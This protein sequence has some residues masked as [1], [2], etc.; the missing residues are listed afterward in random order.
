MPPKI[1]PIFLTQTTLRLLTSLARP[2]QVVPYSQP[3]YPPSLMAAGARNK[4]ERQFIGAK[5]VFAICFNK[6]KRKRK[7]TLKKPQNKLKPVKTPPKPSKTPQILSSFMRVQGKSDCLLEAL[8]LGTRSAITP[9]S[10]SRLSLASDL[11]TNPIDLIKWSFANSHQEM[12]ATRRGHCTTFLCSVQVDGKATAGEIARRK[13]RI[14][15][16]CDVSL[17]P[18]FFYHLHPRCSPSPRVHF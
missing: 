1:I 17:C 8:L 13:W 3:S 11:K 5:I 18:L 9:I 4:V 7:E 15:E 2:L 16:V 6:K 14:S 12:A 10:P